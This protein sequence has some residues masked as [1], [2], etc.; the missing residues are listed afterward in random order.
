MALLQDFGF[1]AQGVILAPLRVVLVAMGL[2][3]A[4]PSRA[5][6]LCPEKD[7]EWIRGV[8]EWNRHV[9]LW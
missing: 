8:E 5:L 1:W 4:V 9:G 3:H 6:W 2:Y 7:G